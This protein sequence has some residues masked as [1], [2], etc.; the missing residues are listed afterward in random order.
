MVGAGTHSVSNRSVRSGTACD[1]TVCNHRDRCRRRGSFAVCFGDVRHL[2]VRSL[3]LSRTAPDHDCRPRLE[4]LGRTYCIADRRA[5][6]GCC[7]RRRFPDCLS[8]RRRH[9]RVVARLSRNARPPG[10][11]HGRRWSASTHARMVSTRASG[12][13]GRSSRHVGCARRHSQFRNGRR[14]FSCRVAR[15]AQRLLARRDLNAGRCPIR[16]AR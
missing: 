11:G 15:R 10:R 4:P 3:V 1:D 6:I 8:C 12:D 2:A 16:Y 14:K 5:H 13:L 9:S 7:L